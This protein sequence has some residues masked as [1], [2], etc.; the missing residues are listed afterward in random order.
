M[1][2]KL[3]REAEEKIQALRKSRKAAMSNFLSTRSSLVSEIQQDTPDL[4]GQRTKETTSAL[5]DVR[6]DPAGM[7]KI[8]DPLKAKIRVL[9][10]EIAAE[11]IHL[12]RLA[13]Q[14]EYDLFS[15]V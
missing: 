9:D 11:E 8:L 4:F 7:A 2:K 1:K 6:K 5:F 10:D 14:P 15:H 12:A 3:M 13:T